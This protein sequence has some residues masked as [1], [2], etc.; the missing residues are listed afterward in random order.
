[1]F[2]VCVCACVCVYAYV[3]VHDCVRQCLRSTCTCMSFVYT[4][5]CVF[6]SI[7]HCRV[8]SRDINSVP[9]YIGQ[10]WPPHG[11]T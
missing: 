10:V 1:M 4:G 7:A 9:G 11:P 6:R 5:V 2:V 3:H 8:E